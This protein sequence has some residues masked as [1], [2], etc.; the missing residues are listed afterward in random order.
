M[1][2]FPVHLFAA[3]IAGMGGLQGVVQHAFYGKP[4]PIGQDHWDRMVQARDERIE[5]ELQ[6]SH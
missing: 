6:S 4:K 2:S 3:M 1:F 5:K